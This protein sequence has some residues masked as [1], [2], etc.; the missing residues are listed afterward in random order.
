MLFIDEMFNLILIQLYF[1]SFLFISF[2][3]FW[4]IAF[5]YSDEERENQD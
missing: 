5:I 4:L 3:F 2:F 1:L